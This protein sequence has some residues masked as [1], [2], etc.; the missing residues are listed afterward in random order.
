MLPIR[1][2]LDDERAPSWNT[3]YSGQHW[4]KRKA[5]KDAA[6]LVVLAALP[7]DA[8]PYDVPVDIHITACYPRQP[9]DAD[10]VCSKVYIDA[11]KGR[12]LHED[13]PRWVRSVTT[14]SQRAKRASVVIELI[15]A[16]E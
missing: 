15:P 13:N 12:L 1:I 11:L 6:R 8:T 3:F 10:N 5:L 2:R 9:L 4:S 16:N 7:P 14:V